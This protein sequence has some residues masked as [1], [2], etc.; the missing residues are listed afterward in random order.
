MSL[1]NTSG[2]TNINSGNPLQPFALE[3]GCQDT[4]LVTAAVPIVNLGS[5]D[6]SEQVQEVGQIAP[7]IAQALADAYIDAAEFVVANN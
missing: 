2:S 5:S 3:L 7:K 6:P 1:K 4:D